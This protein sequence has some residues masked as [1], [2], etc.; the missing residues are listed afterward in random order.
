MMTTD[1]KCRAILEKFVQIL[2]KDI[3][4]ELEPDFGGNTMTI[5]VG[6]S[7]THVGIPPPDDDFDLMVDNLYNAV[8]GGPGLSWHPEYPVGEENEQEGQEKS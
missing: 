3:P 6:G 8:H 7:H 1:E 5:S 4:I 2:D